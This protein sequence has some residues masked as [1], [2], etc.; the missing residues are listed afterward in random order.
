MKK[1]ILV[2]GATG[3][4]GS[5]IVPKLLENNLI[6]KVYTLTRR[7]FNLEHPKLEKIISNENDFIS[8][9]TGKNIQSFIICFGTT[10]KK[11]GS[12]E[13]FYQVD[14]D[15]P[16][17]IATKVKEIGCKEV[18]F[19]SSVG[20]NSKSPS[21]YL[22]CKG[23]LEDKLTELNFDN[24][25]IYRPNILDGKRLEKRPIEKLGIKFGNKFKQLNI[26]KFLWPTKVSELTDLVCLNLCEAND[27]LK[28]Y[29]GSEL[30]KI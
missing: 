9:L 11:A 20:A 15:I 8:S 3:L 18:H 6:D 4:I 2:L 19:I 10:I 29:S 28:I 7:D 23:E 16:L 12:K 30:K 5:D 22:K 17:S 21:F 25:K 1:N 24:L 14:V 26:F 13:R 27:K